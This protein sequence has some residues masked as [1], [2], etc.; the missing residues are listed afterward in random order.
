MSTQQLTTAVRL[1]ADA[2]QL[3]ATYQQAGRTVEGFSGQVASYS[4]QATQAAS[5]ASGAFGQ[6][7]SHLS[8]VLQ[9]AAE[10]K[11]AGLGDV[12]AGW[13]R[14]SGTLEAAAGLADK[15]LKGMGMSAAATAAA[16]RNV[17]AQIT[18]IVTS[19]QG[20]MPI[21]TVAMQQ[22]GQLRDMFGGIAP[23]AKALGATV[24]GMVNPF[25]LAAVA[26]GV[27]AYAY[28]A[29]SSEA[30]GYRAALVMTGNAA[31]TT[32]G[33]MADMARAVAQNIG[34]Q[35]AAAAVLAQMAGT[36][37]IA[38]ES[39][40][41]FTAVALGLEKYA[42]QAIKTT[43]QQLEKLGESPVQASIKLNEQYRY[44]SV[45][46]YE[47]IKALDEQGKKDEAAALAQ[48]TY[49][50]AMEA[51][52]QQLKASLGSI[53]RG[54]MA[55]TT[56]A[57]KG[58][59]A[60][61]N[62]GREETAQQK[63]DAIG[64]RIAALRK[65]QEGGGFA[66]TAGGAAVGRGNAGG[67]AR[68]RELAQ[69]LAEQAALQ[70]SV[71]LER[72][73]AEAAAERADAVNRRV[74][75]DKVVESN[76]SKQAKLEKEIKEIRAKGADAGASDAEIEA[77]VRAH[78]AKA[79]PGAADSAINAQIEG[80]Q[81]AYKR[82]AAATAD[83]IAA[84][85]AQRQQGLLAE[86]TAIQ[87]ASALRLQDIDNQR[88]ALQQ[89][90]DIAKKKREAKKEVARLKGEL[91]TLDQKRQNTEAQR[92]R[93]VDT[94]LIKPQLELV[95][96][97][98]QAAA[99]AD[100][101]AAAQERQ[102]LVIGKSKSAVQDILVV[103]LERQRA[104]LQATETVIPGYLDMLDQRIA[105]E[106]RLAQALHTQDQ[107]EAALKA[108]EKAKEDAKKA[109]DG[110]HEVFR[111]GFTS[112]FSQDASF[113]TSFGKA[114]K[115]TVAGA[116]ADAFYSATAKN[117][118]EQFTLWF[119]AQ[120]TAA[121]ASS[122][123]GG[124][125]SSVLGAGIRLLGGGTGATATAANALPGDSL[126]NFIGLNNN[127]VTP[128]AKGG[129]YVDGLAAHRNTIV[130]Q[131]TRFAFAKGA[132]LVGE[133]PGSPGE[134]ILPLKRMRGG[135]LGVAA[136]LTGGGRAGGAFVYAPTINVDSR[137]DRA[138][139][140]QDMRQ[141]AADQAKAQREQLQRMKVIPA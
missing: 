96:A 30:D 36:G 46:V 106:K 118:V 74:A 22:G 85:E 32:V 48:Q 111:N 43:V 76:L 78:R 4:R 66:E 3:T 56:A 97:Q 51:R 38:G 47:A 100:E 54:W 99:S 88:A 15:N 21:M 86:V 42:G 107:Q 70:E 61:L 135:D 104:D 40:E 79:N 89:E 73:G 108:R 103:E 117:A 105:A 1:T 45:T 17:P 140:I 12:M 19:L 34:T 102:N 109:V 67:Q 29:G 6:L 25:T 2:S 57:K 53:E 28:H 121:T 72:R 113:V 82:Q 93:D 63:L 98:R 119:R 39:L 133:A 24:L 122:S 68:E 95:R 16:M 114:L 55:V 52:T 92:D 58:W 131:P 115:T 87:R 44:L 8:G 136:E 90:I 41:H 65:M 69:L 10:M 125:F 14:S 77:Q 101:A 37:Q 59:D 80:I 138:A 50:N 128:N 84:V 62:I 116:V 64:T 91:E 31:G 94:A 7:T 33:Q 126:D 26:A 137:A 139:A 110:V 127:F 123:S 112:L 134:G 75:W 124:L 5:T 23:A 71:R 81:Q 60:I 120:M 83:G 27:L 35:S 132:G 49:A 13:A 141:V 11:S 129:A 9:G 18:D 130:T 20:G